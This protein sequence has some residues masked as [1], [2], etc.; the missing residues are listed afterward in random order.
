MKKGYIAKLLACYVLGLLMLTSKIL[1]SRFL[2]SDWSEPV[3]IF[4]FIAGLLVIILAVVGNSF[5]SIKEDEERYLTIVEETGL[6][7]KKYYTEYCKI[8]LPKGKD[9][10]GKDTSTNY[11]S[12]F[13]SLLEEYNKV[14]NKTGDVDSINNKEN[15]DD[16]KENRCGKNKKKSEKKKDL[17]DD[18]QYSL[19]RIKRAATEEIFLFTTV[20]L[21]LEIGIVTLFIDTDEFPWP[22]KLVAV[23]TCTLALLLLFSSVLIRDRRIINFVKDVAKVLKIPMDNDE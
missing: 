17:T 20:L 9:K 7:I 22:V 3:T 6:K 8:G 15:N 23:V 16:I 12:W 10:H 5:Y 2:I 4:L 14:V 1:T 11:S 19:I 13:T 21:P 18:M